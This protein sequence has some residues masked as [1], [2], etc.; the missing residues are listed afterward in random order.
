MERCAQE[1]ADSTFLT[2]AMAS[3]FEQLKQLT[4]ADIAASTD[5]THATG[6]NWEPGIT[7]WCHRD[8]RLRWIANYKMSGSIYSRIRRRHSQLII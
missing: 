1:D 6:G 3:L 8:V 2:A 7:Q 5:E 4:G